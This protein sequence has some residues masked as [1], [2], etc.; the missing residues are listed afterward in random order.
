MVVATRAKNKAARPATAVMTEKVK[1]KVGIK[2]TRHPKK[3]TKD[4]TIQ[5]LHAQI[6]RLENPSEETFSKEPLVCTQKL[7]S[8]MHTKC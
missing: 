4:Q 1:K 2:T 8:C 6:A 7:P 3:L 5:E